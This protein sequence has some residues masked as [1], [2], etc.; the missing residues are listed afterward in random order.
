MAYRLNILDLRGCCCLCVLLLTFALNS[1]NTRRNFQLLG[2]QLWLDNLDYARIGLW[3]SSVARD[4]AG[5]AGAGAPGACLAGWGRCG[6]IRFARSWQHLETRE[7]RIIALNRLTRLSY[8]LLYIL[9]TL[10]KRYTRGTRTAQAPFTSI[11]HYPPAQSFLCFKQIR[12][13]VMRWCSCAL[14]LSLLTLKANRF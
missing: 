8:A 10:T 5:A 6:C 1:Q 4:L 14:S 11:K 7:Q 9:L 3:N 12:P 13:F 2:S